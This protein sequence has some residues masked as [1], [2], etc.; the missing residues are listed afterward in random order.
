[1]RFS[2]AGALL[3]VGAQ[4]LHEPVVLDAHCLGEA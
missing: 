4:A 1:L 2:D 3:Q